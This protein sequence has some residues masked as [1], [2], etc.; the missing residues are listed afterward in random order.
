MPCFDLRPRLPRQRTW[1]RIAIWAAAASLASASQADAL[2]M[3]ARKFGLSCSVCHTSPPRLTETGRRFRASGFRPPQADGEEEKQPFN[4]FDYSSARLQ[5]RLS[6]S[7]S[8]AGAQESSVNELKFQALELYPFTGAWGKYLSSDIKVT[9]STETDP[10]IEI[11]YLRVNAGGFVARAGIFHPYDG[12]GASDSPATISRPF[13]QSTPANFNQTTFFR[14]WGFDELGAEA[15]FDYRRTS[16]RAA[17]LNGLVLHQD[18]GRLTAYAAQGGPLTRSSALPAHDFPDFQIFV[19]QTLHA[20]GGGVSFHYYHGNLA[21]PAGATA[22]FRDRFDRVALYGSYPAHQR[23][24]LLAGIQ[25]GRDETATADHFGS[26][27]VFA[28]AAVPIVPLTAAGVRYDWFD[29]ARNNADNELRGITAYL[30]AWFRE[31]FRV[32]A[33]YQHK[34]TRRGPLPAQDDDAFQIRFIY[35][36]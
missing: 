14:T 1:T 18:N 27:G 33:E 25:G 32:V 34:H 3:F 8:R 20:D 9:F 2:P 29:P 17:L 7:R 22:S 30:N 16:V 11:A 10:Q 26:R 19:N 13:F 36:K 15:G 4:F 35:I 6:E 28:E 31:Q 5:V 21:L 12:Y 23:L 24:H